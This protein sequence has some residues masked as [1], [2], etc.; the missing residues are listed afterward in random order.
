MNDTDKVCVPV[1]GRSYKAR[2]GWRVY[3]CSVNV[4]EGTMS[5]EHF[6]PEILHGGWVPVPVIQKVGVQFNA[7][8]LVEEWDREAELQKRLAK[9]ANIPHEVTLHIKLDDAKI[10][11]GVH[12]EAIK[13][14]KTVPEY[15]ADYVQESLSFVFGAEDE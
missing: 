15:L 12:R 8:D 4:I 14:G 3:V 1:S 6:T 5:V 2:G 13:E 11:H 9:P 10:R 7:F